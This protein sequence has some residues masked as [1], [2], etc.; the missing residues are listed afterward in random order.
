[1]WKLYCS[2]LQK[3]T[4]TAC[5]IRMGPRSAVELCYMCVPSIGHRSGAKRLRY[6]QSVNSQ[7]WH[8]HCLTLCVGCVIITSFHCRVCRLRIC[9]LHVIRLLKS[10]KPGARTTLPGTRL[11]QQHMLM[12]NQKSLNTWIPQPFYMLLLSS[13][14]PVRTRL[15]VCLCMCPEG[16]HR[17]QHTI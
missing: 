9:S 3:L 8:S 14:G 15:C 6:V 4:G 13:T 5:M 1:M 7:T 10:S 16:E 12:L 17:L 2:M 11:Q